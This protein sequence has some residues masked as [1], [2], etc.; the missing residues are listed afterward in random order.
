MPKKEISIVLD[1]APYENHYIA[2]SDVSGHVLIEADKDKP[3]YK[4]IQV[5]LK[6]YALVSIAEAKSD[7]SGNR[8]R[9]EYRQSSEDYTTRTIEVWSKARSPENQLTAGSHR[10]P[11]SFRIR[12][13]G[14]PSFKGTAGGIYYQ[15]DARIVSVKNKTVRTCWPGASFQYSPLVDLNFDLKVLQPRIL[16]VQ[17]TLCCFCCASGPISLTVRI[18]RTGYCCTGNDAIPLEVDIENG[19]N[20]RIRFLKANLKRFVVYI[21]QGRSVHDRDIIA[22][23]KSDTAIR[24]GQ[25][26]TWRPPPLSIP[27]TVA[28][29][30]TCS[31]IKLRYYLKVQAVVFGSCNPNVKFDLVL[32]NVPIQGSDQLTV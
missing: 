26:L 22:R 14:P 11:F 8:W 5:S 2:N 28:S 10:F 16:Q 4:S 18:P 1:P 29:F 13:S 7:A 23:T 6:G 31:I 9:T 17:K 19:S 32:G 20:R 24:A 12:L 21:A 30:T 15:V 3:N 25:S 27:E